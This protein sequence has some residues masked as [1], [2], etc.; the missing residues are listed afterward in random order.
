MKKIIAL[1]LLSIFTFACT[2]APTPEVIIITVV[3]QPTLPMATNTQT[4]TN[5]P[6]ATN[7]PIPTLEITPTVTPNPCLLW[8]QVTSEM[9]GQTVCVRGIIRVIDVTRG[10][11]K[12]EVNGV[13]VNNNQT[14]WDFTDNRTGFFSVSIYRGW[15]TVTGKDM[16]VGDCVAI[17]GV[18][19]V[20]PNGRPY[21]YWGAN[22]IPKYSNTHTF[23]F[24]HPDLQV[25]EDNP[26]FCQ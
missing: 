4:A 19:Q 1:I 10:N 7:T 2:P 25:I 5:I 3:V 6:T 11:G 13:Y 24:E 9:A 22:S 20:L 12:R 16:A 17:T 15:H 23:Y 18:I 21:I 26:F 8:D 14:H